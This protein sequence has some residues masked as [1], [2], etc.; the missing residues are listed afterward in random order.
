[1]KHTP[2][3]WNTDGERAEPAEWPMDQIIVMDGSGGCICEVD[4]HT[5]WQTTKANAAF[6]V[7]A[8]NCHDELVAA[9]MNMVTHYAP[10]VSDL[11][12]NSQTDAILRDAV[13]ALARVE[14]Q[15]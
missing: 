2:T 3:P 11:S 4:C 12:G 8:C 13:A 15:P 7:H 14:G 5:D 10:M 1:M 6:I 9:L